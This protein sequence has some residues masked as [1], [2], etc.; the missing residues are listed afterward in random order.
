VDVAPC[1][2]A[3]LEDWA[4]PSRVTGPVD[5]LADKLLPLRFLVI[6]VFMG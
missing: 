6:K 4:L 3:F 5:F 2:N 1:T